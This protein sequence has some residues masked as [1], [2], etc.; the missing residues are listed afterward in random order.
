M[1]M[2]ARAEKRGEGFVMNDTARRSD[3]L[4]AED[5]TEMHK[6]EVARVPVYFYQAG[7][8]RYANLKDAI[9]Q[10]KREALRAGTRE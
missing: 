7:Q 1:P 10:A 3:D 4:T 5:L 2:A 9:A 8:Y 6:Y